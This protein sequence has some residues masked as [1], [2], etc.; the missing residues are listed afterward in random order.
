V[1]AARWF[2]TRRRLRIKRRFGSRSPFGTKRRFRSKRRFGSKERGSASVWVLAVGLTVVAVGV[3][4]ASVGAAVVARHQAQAA[5]DLGALAAAV[6]AV[7]GQEA[8]C[9]RATAIVTANGGRMVSCQVE[10]L[11]AV[12]G[13]EVDAAGLAATF[14]PAS[15][16]ARAG[17]VT[18]T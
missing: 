5:A 9:A 10:G 12:V 17:P 13:A 2:G 15:A 8:A 16:K 1:I 18:S 14:R 6:H 3:F 11:E 4:G 7:E